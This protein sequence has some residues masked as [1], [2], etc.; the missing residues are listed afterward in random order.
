MSI[1]VLHNKIVKPSVNGPVVTHEK[2][3]VIGGD[4]FKSEDFQSKAELLEAVNTEHIR[5]HG[6]EMD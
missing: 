3:T 1:K 6:F 5:V 2:F 4:E